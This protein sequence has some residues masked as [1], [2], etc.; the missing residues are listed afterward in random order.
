[1]LARYHRD[2]EEADK[3][4]FERFLPHNG[5][6][7]NASEP[8]LDKT[9]RLLG[10]EI[11]RACRERN[12]S[13]CWTTDPAQQKPWDLRKLQDRRDDEAPPAAR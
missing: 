6:N 10:E 5:I 7:S 3:V 9:R 11:Y 13:S 1:M 12:I 4:Y 2:V 8:N